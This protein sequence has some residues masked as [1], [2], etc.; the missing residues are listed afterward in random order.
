MK[1]FRLAMVQHDAYLGKKQ[2]NLEKT[3]YYVQKA[4]E[5]GARLVAFPEINISGHAAHPD[6]RLSGESIP[7]G[8]SVRLL[9]KLAK[10]LDIFIAAGIVE[11]EGGKLYNTQF[12]VGPDGFIGKQRK[13]HLSLNESLYF[14]PGDTIRTIELPFVKAGIVICYDSFFPEVSRS[15]AIQGAE[16]L[17]LCNAAR[18]VDTEWIEWLADEE[19]QARIVKGMKDYLCVLARCRA[20]ENRCYAGVCNMTGES[21]RHVGVKSNHAGGSFIIDPCGK[22]LAESKT[23][24]IEDEMI[25]A[26]LSGSLLARLRAHENSPFKKRRAQLF[27]RL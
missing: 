9:G 19:Y 3:I 12:V 27:S 24:R 6:L 2:E 18:H 20:L 14:T 21:G 26:G 4:H 8:K 1:D 13:I 5:A 17:L 15:L 25:S 7:E 16:L 10:D 22:I 11:L 23:A